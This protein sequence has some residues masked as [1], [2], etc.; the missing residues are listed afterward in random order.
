MKVE[1]LQRQVEGLQ[2][3]VKGL[4]QENEQLR[5]EN[6]GLREIIEKLNSQVGDGNKPK[7][8]AF[9]K[10]NKPKVTR[11]PEKNEPLNKTKGGGG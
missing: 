1:R 10:A 3:A 7:P 9:V 4:Q 5:Q 11:K 2:E 6:E 8:P